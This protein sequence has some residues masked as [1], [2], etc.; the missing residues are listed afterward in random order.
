LA[1]DRNIDGPPMSIC[2]MVSAS[3]APRATVCSNGYRLT[4]LAHLPP[5][6]LGGPPQQPAV[7]FGVQR[8]DPAVEDFGRAGVVRDGDGADAGLFEPGPGAAGR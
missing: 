7:N 4:L 8:L 1:A 3:P 5:M 6:I 2:S